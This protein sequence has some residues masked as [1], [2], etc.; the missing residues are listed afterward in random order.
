MGHLLFPTGQVDYTG[1]GHTDHGYKQQTAVAHH[2]ILWWWWQ[3][4]STKHWMSAQ[5]WWGQLP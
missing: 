3:S 2:I 5:N 1:S 4:V